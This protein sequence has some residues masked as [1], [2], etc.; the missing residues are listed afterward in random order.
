MRKIALFFILAS[1][2]ACHENTSL[3]TGHEGEIVP[4]FDLLLPDSTTHFNTQNIQAGQPFAI[5]FVG[6]HCPFSRA[7][8]DDILKNSKSLQNYH[9]YVLTVEP[10]QDLKALCNDYK[11]DQYPN[12]TVGLDYSYFFARHFHDQA[13]PYLAVY[14]GNRRLK[15]VLQG[16]TPAS[17]IRVA[18]EKKD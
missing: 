16:S 6:T 7:E 10:L 13:V 18:L 11:F 15:E 8:L 3:K 14:G 4:S 9:F 12:F 2:M 1:L 17:E 5:L